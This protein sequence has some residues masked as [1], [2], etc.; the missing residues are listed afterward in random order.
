MKV[1]SSVGKLVMNISSYRLKKYYTFHERP[2]YS[3]DV[4][5]ISD[6]LESYD[7]GMVIQGPIKEEDDF[8]IETVRLYKKIFPGIKIVVSTWKTT[9]MNVVLKLEELNAEVLL[10]DEKELPENVGIGHINHQIYT[11]SEGIRR[12]KDMGCKYICKT[13]TDQRIYANNVFQYLITLLEAFPIQVVSE[14][15]KRI[16]MINMGSFSDRYYN[17]SDL[18]SFGTTEDM[19]RYWCVDFDYRDVK[20]IDEKIKS[21]GN[22]Q[23][24]FSRL[25]TGEIYFVTKYIETLKFELKWNV[26]DSEFY[27]ANLFVIVDKESIDLYWRKYSDKEYRWKKY[28]KGIL[29]EVNF[30]DWLIMWKKYCLDN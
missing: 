27:M 3:E 24:E 11:T 22:D 29:N 12:L 23:K 16:V 30:K 8:T 21:I 19:E 14:A 17:I 9:N 2:K 15:R 6:N 20:T 1:L 7:V 10:L 4:E 25:R 28:Q 18:F 13:R 26:E 5:I